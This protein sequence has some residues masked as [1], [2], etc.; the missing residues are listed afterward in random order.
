MPMIGKSL[1][2]PV[3]SL[4]TFFITVD[5]D[6]QMDTVY[7][8]IH[9]IGKGASQVKT[10]EVVKRTL[11]GFS[12]TLDVSKASA[13]RGFQIYGFNKGRLVA[14]LIGSS[15]TLQQQETAGLYLSPPE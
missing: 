15:L 3:D 1:P 6:I 10:S 14:Q 2:I 4:R 5:P 7:G 9:E 11:E 8:C 12:L 13:S